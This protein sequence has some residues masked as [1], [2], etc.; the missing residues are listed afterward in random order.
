[1]SIRA[2]V[3]I[4][5]FAFLAGCA[6]VVTAPSELPCDNVVA[7]PER[8]TA[9]HRYADTTY[10]VGNIPG[11]SHY[12]DTLALWI[13]RWPDARRCLTLSDSLNIHASRS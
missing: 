3:G 11:T 9:P 5:A 8:Y 1:M 7:P 6:D 13:A 12:G 10:L 2:H 4:L